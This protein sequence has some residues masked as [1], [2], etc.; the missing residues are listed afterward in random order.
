MLFAVCCLFV[1]V[2]FKPVIYVATYT[3]TAV[4]GILR[5]CF[6]NFHLENT[7]AMEQIRNLPLQ[8]RFSIG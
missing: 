5:Y 4:A 2:M 6:I 8:M 1:N 7:D 3:G